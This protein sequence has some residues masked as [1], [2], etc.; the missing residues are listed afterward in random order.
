ME[1]GNQQKCNKQ[2]CRGGTKPIYFI[3]AKA[4]SLGSA[5]LFAK[6]NSVCGATKPILE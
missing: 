1:G 5:H 3:K 2:H 4:I 6:P